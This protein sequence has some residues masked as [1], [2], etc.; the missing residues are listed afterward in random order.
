MS[1]PTDTRAWHAC[2][3]S[4]NI[5]SQDIPPFCPLNPAPLTTCK[6]LP[7]RRRGLVPALPPIA[8]R[9]LR[10]RRILLR[11]APILIVLML[12]IVWRAA[13]PCIRAV[14]ALRGAVLLR[15][16]HR[17]SIPCLLAVRGPAMLLTLRAGVPAVLR[18]LVLAWRGRAVALGGGR[19]GLVLPAV[20]PAVASVLRRGRAV[21]AAGLV[22]RW[23]GAAG[24]RVP[25]GCVVAVSVAAVGRLVVL[26]GSDGVS[27][28]SGRLLTEPPPSTPPRRP[29]R[30]PP[31]EL[32]C[33]D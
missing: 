13:I 15:R 33:P 23:R 7:P 22:R 29:P 12:V 1:H 21:R 27:Y 2:T 18:L 11:R 16:V 30:P 25:R 10:R 19:V 5:I 17:P 4:I 26:L 28:S 31:L 20:L 9:L 8:M 14:L 6:H 24:V 3:P 32:A